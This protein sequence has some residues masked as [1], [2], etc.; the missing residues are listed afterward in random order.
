MVRLPLQR[1]CRREIGAQRQ[2]AGRCELPLS[3]VERELAHPQLIVA[4]LG[5]EPSVAH[6][7]AVLR[8]VDL[9]TVTLDLTGER[10]RTE[11]ASPFEIRTQTTVDDRV[12]PGEHLHR[13][14]RGE[15]EGRDH[16]RRCAA[17]ERTALGARWWG[18]LQTYIRATELGRTGDD[19]CHER[20]VIE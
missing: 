20:V 19:R 6:G 8:R 17:I 16:V 11:A 9:E 1:G 5:A 14:E 13:L 10:N 18:Q 4:D 3:C 12:G 7:D 15:L 2:G